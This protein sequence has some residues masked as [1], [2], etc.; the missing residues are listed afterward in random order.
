[1]QSF[2]FYDN[3][4]NIGKKAYVNP[5]SPG[6]T[7]K[8]L[9]LIEDT[10]YSGNDTIFV[11]TYQPKR[12][13]N[14][15]ALEG[16]LYI[17]TNTYALQNVI[18]KSAQRSIL[19][20]KIEQKYEYLGNK[21]WFPVQLNT[22]ITL[23]IGDA[24]ITNDGEKMTP[25]GAGR[26]YIKNIK[27]NPELKRREFD[28]IVVDVDENAADK[29]N[30]YWDEYRIAPLDPKEIRTYEFLDSIGKEINI[31]KYTRSFFIFRS[32]FIP[33]WK[34][35][36]DI[37]E[38]VR[39]ND[40]EGLRLGLATKTNHRLS[41]WFRLGGYFAYGTRDKAFKYGGGVRFFIDKNSEFE[42]G[43]F[44]SN[45][46]AEHGVEE[47]YQ[48]KSLF[49]DA[50]WR[51]FLIKEMA[52]VKKY[53]MQTE[54][55]TLRY[56]KMQGMVNVYD[57]FTGFNPS[58][59]NI[60]ETAPNR[61]NIT[62][63]SAGFRYAYKEKIIRTPQQQFIQTFSDEPVKTKYPTI[64]F[65]YTAGM[66]L[67]GGEHT[68]SRY[69]VKLEKSF[70]MKY[71]GTSSFKLEGG[72]IDTEV[73]F[74][75]LYNGRSSYRLFTIA[76]SNSFATMHM[77]E[78][79]SDRYASLFFDHNFGKLIIRTERFT[80]EFHI[81]TNMIV[82]DLINQGEDIGNYN[83]LEKG[84]FES[85]LAIR[86][87]LNLKLFKIGLG[88]YYRYGEYAFDDQIDNFSFRFSVNSPF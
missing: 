40:F 6:S 44:Y 23:G 63:V 2:S 62:E 53:G 50:F 71:F 18:A 48:D 3:V 87:F 26:T 4:I 34:F 54:L 67:L 27:I 73:P 82:G 51:S 75:R 11:I 22:E 56:F 88:A 66:D 42:A 37:K 80:P 49:S 65:Q 52:K 85:G 38:V 61:Y 68:Y 86:K 84:Y 41:E 15:E 43:A 70:Y 39:Y 10:L 79:F 59:S 32:G 20:T 12:N 33:V 47:I 30:G 1:M 21:Q 25:V 5:I 58:F 55:R 45:D 57:Y 9:F 35:S 17:N 72:Y 46:V 60:G 8:Y 74:V 14:F 16:V 13:K 81:V 19:S 31:E 64:W 24:D 78:F 36:F 29:K 83:T 76:S 77:D 7:R 69:D 28:H